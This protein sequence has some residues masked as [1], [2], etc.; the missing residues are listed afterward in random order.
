MEALLERAH[1]VHL[2]ITCEVVMLVMLTLQAMYIIVTMSALI[3][4]MAMLQM[5]EEDNLLPSLLLLL[6]TIMSFRL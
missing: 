3:L 2:I 4:F 5:L 6:L 1:L